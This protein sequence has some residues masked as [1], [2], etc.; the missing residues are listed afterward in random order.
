[1]PEESSQT[2]PQAAALRSGR[3]VTFLIVSVGL[4]A[5]ASFSLL[6]ISAGPSLRL[7]TCFQDV[8]GLRPGAKVRLAGVEVGAVREVRAQPTNKTAQAQSRWNSELLTN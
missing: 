3:W 8:S 6:K 1:M 4:L 5:L 7:K 2:S